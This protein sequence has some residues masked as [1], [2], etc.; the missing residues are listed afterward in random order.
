MRVASIASAV[1]MSRAALRVGPPPR[2]RRSSRIRAASATAARAAEAAVRTRR[3]AAPRL[4]RREATRS[5]SRAS[6]GSTT[7]DAVARISPNAEDSGCEPSTSAR[8]DCTADVDGDD[9]HRERDPRLRSPFE[10]FCGDRI[11]ALRPEAPHE[12]DRGRRV[13]QRGQG[14]PGQRQA[15]VD[16][17]DDKS[18][19]ADG[20]VPRDREVREPQRRGDKVGAVADRLGVQPRSGDEE[21]RIRR[22]RGSRPRGRSR[23]SEARARR[24]SRRRS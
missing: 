21:A 8:M 1:A 14:E 18:G 23:S 9:K 10:M 19:D 11:V 24:P 22:R 5:F 2:Q 7:S 6:Q 3:H 15:A 4:A 13:E 16:D 20:A 12:H 17:R